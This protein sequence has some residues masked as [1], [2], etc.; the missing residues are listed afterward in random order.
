MVRIK[1]CVPFCRRTH[2]SADLEW[3]CGEHW[4][5]VPQHQR[6]WKHRVFRLYRRAFGEN[7]FWHYPAGSPKRLQAIRLDRIRRRSWEQCKRDA[8]ERAGGLK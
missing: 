5:L 3:M 7:G 8:I 2:K 4:A 6:R 1:C